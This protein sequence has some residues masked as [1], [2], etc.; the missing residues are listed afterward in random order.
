MLDAFIGG[1]SYWAIGWGLAYGEGGNF[2]CGGSQYF[3]YQLP[4]HHYP[5][6][7]F[8]VE[9]M[10]DFHVKITSTWIIAGNLS[11]AVGRYH[12]RT[13]IIQQVQVY[14]GVV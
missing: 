10:Y 9:I 11:L 5:K 14:A 6:W 1:L 8:Q 4:H 2:F 7:F 12:L 13:F 3:N